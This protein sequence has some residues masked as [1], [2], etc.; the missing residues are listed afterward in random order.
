M[1][2]IEFHPGDCRAILPA[3][4]GE[5][6]QLIITSPPYNVGW[7]YA[8]N[9]TGDRLSLTA[10]TGGLLAPVVDECYRVLRRGGVL[11]VN[12]PPTIRIKGQHCAW[13][14]GAWLQLHLLAGPWLFQEP[15]VWVKGRV[16]EA[17]AKTTAIGA[18]TVSYR[19]PTHE[20]VI[21]ANKATYRIDKHTFRREE[22]P[23]DV[24][25][26]VWHIPP[27]PARRGLPAPFPDELVR[28]LVCIFSRPGD[29]VLDPF[30]GLGTVG[31]VARSLGRRAWL[32]EREPS[33][34]LR[35]EG[36]AAQ[37]LLDVT[38]AA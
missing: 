14:V 2:F 6:V 32:I 17:R 13:P 26:D 37:G 18:A 7:P 15:Q 12:L 19:R 5:S 27:A 1:P 30:A 28:R 20:L 29:V 3:L 33:Y 22:V 11:A 31:R 16:G 35:L 10:Y 4:P 38:P 8:D 23:L 34:W 24:L 25:K 36:L 21:I 9:G